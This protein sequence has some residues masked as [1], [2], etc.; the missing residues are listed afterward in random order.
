[1]HGMHKQN[2][3]LSQ[4]KT[5]TFARM[6]DASSHLTMA[7]WKNVQCN[8]DG[9]DLHDLMETRK[10][11]SSM[12]THLFQKRKVLQVG[13]EDLARAHRSNGVRRTWSH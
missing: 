5:H 8:F 1:M 4:P 10:M 2:T 7:L 3:H 13:D 11:S 12:A 6:S 9:F